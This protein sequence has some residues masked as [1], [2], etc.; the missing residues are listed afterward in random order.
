MGADEKP[1]DRL[2]AR[3]KRE[4]AVRTNLNDWTEKKGITITD[5]VKR[6]NESYNNVKRWLSDESAVLPLGFVLAL[7]DAYPEQLGAEDLFPGYSWAQQPSRR[8]I[9]ELQRV[10]ELLNE[11]NLGEEESGGDQA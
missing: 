9:K 10:Q 3:V 8:V 4:N 6:T 7:L 5:I 2:K 1:Q 11:L